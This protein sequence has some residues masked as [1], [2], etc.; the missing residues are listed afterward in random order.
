MIEFKSNL[1]KVP[2][3]RGYNLVK[4]TKEQEAMLFE[5]N[6]NEV[7]SRRLFFMPFV[8]EQPLDDWGT[9]IYRI[10]RF[11]EVSSFEI[12]LHDLDIRKLTIEELKEKYPGNEF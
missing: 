7:G 3:D 10:R 2:S 12:G 4:L 6:I 1:E 9:R 8:F 5:G 11:G